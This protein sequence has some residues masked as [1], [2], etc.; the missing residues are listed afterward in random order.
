MQKWEIPDNILREW[1]LLV[2]PEGCYPGSP[3]LR[4]IY[5]EDA[6]TLQAANPSGMTRLLISRHDKKVSSPYKK[7][8]MQTP[9]GP[10]YWTPAQ[11]GRHAE[12][13]SA[14]LL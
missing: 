4:I 2:F 13:V 14:S 5:E 10:S 7:A 6:G 3:F 1:H 9:K 12:F 11:R 8:V